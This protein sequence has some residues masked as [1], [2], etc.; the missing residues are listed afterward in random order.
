M[1]MHVLQFYRSAMILT[2]VVSV[3]FCAG[4]SASS[5]DSR[6]G[7][8]PGQF[9]AGFK[10]IELYDYSRT[11][12]EKVDDAGQEY[13]GERARPV[14][15]CI[16]YP[17]SKSTD[18]DAVVFG[19]YVFPAPDDFRFFAFVSDIQGREVRNILAIFRG[20]NRRGLDFQ[21][22]AMHAIRDAEPYDS[23]FPVVI[24]HPGIQS[25]VAENAPLCEYLASHGYVVATTHSVGAAPG[26]PEPVPR[27][28][29]A[30]VRDR[31]FVLAH[32]F[33]LPFADMNAV[34]VIGRGTGAAA[35]TIM[36][37]RND[38]VEAA[39]LLDPPA[40][41]D[42]FYSLLSSHTD[43]DTW[44]ADVPYLFCCRGDSS[45]AYSACI[46]SFPYSERQLLIIDAATM[47][48][49]TVYALA[50]ADDSGGGPERYA[51]I[52]DN[53][54]LFLDARLNKSSEAIE[55]LAAMGTQFDAVKRPPTENQFR[56][57]LRALEVDRALDVY[58]QLHALYPDR[59]ILN[60]AVMNQVGYNLIG[61]NRVEDAVRIMRLNTESFP[62]SPNVWDSY[63]DA[64]MASGDVPTAIQCYHKVLEILPQ[65][66]VTDGELKEQL[67]NIAEHALQELEN[68]N[69]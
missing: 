19:E 65:D 17:I 63:A 50:A 24:Y 16:W 39:V 25:G 44:Q 12:R 23:T 18:G 52:C 30:M 59:A 5:D 54:R 28:L 26:V 51:S 58:E 7:A 20:D 13:T 6:A 21:N 41:D 66:T 22:R 11:F 9:G 57:L 10:T 8:S 15:I 69:E 61:V 64:C 35:A 49:F 1:G 32:L 36:Q 29:E 53:V 3:I 48:D 60:E 4:Q 27:D 56:N 67:R 40:G 33:D 47:I 42:N 37:M 45:A 46:D 14:Q 38:F 55:H 43:F 62:Q 34:G 68:E 2:T 31:E